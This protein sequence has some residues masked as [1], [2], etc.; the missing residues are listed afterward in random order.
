MVF[1]EIGQVVAG[2]HPVGDGR[3]TRLGKPLRTGSALTKTNTS[4][5]TIVI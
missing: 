5:K 1:I 3:G 2:A 4:R